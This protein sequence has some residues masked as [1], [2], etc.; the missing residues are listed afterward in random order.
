MKV[1]SIFVVLFMLT[2]TVCCALDRQDDTGYEPSQ[3][4]DNSTYLGNE[5]DTSIEEDGH[6]VTYKLS[7]EEQIDVLRQAIEKQQN[8]K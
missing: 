8:K 2:T 4:K 1:L 6:V 3:E 5:G 7:D